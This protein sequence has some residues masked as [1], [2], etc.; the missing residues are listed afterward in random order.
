[1]AVPNKRGSLIA[2]MVVLA[3]SASALSARA[4]EFKLKGGRKL[5]GVIVSYE[6]N[7]FK[8]KTEFG[9]ELIEKDK[10][11]SII[12]IDAGYEI[13]A[14]IDREEKCNIPTLKNRGWG[15]HDTD[16]SVERSDYRSIGY[17]SEY[18]HKTGEREHRS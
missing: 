6:D 13:R 16:R 4:D 3:F 11:E 17:G 12:P 5:Y 14:D 9:Y 10:I 18:R 7:M 15:T 8:I 2:V 1:M